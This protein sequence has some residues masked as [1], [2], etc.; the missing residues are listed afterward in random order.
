MKES[1]L[2]RKVI[3]TCNWL[4]LRHYHTFDSR[5][6]AAGF[7]D[8][9]IVGPLGVLFVELKSDKGLVS[10]QQEA[11]VADLERAGAEAFI[12]RPAGFD[13]LVK[14]LKYISGK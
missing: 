5:K 14:R 12:I 3:E 13:H 11:W 8:L 9:V 10:P 6:S 4:G 7:P 2:Q 1:E